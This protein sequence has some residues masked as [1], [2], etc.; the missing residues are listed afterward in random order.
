MNFNLIDATIFY[1]NT[2]GLS[3]KKMVL[4]ITLLSFVFTSCNTIV[5]KEEQEVLISSSPENA[6]I[7]VDGKYYG[8]TPSVVA[9]TPQDSHEIVITKEGFRAETYHLQSKVAPQKLAKN[10]AFPIGGL[11]VGGAAG[12]AL[13]GG[14]AGGPIAAAI[15]AFLIGLAACVGLVTGTIV[16][17]VGTGVDAHTGEANNLAS[18]KV[19]LQLEP[20]KPS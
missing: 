8:V 9:L 14:V 18:E 6:Q 19:H 1:F 13:V 12:A 10:L 17:V 20:A 3:M 2:I 15:G 11:L 4:I 7:V 5:H 16:G